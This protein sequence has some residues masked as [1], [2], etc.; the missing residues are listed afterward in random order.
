[1]NLTDLKQWTTA[2]LSLVESKR[3]KFLGCEN[4]FYLS[5]SC[6]YKLE[7]SAFFL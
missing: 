3:S 7:E 4:I 5:V 2:L 1:M 6:A